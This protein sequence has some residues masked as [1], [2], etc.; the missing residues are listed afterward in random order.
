[1]TARRISIVDCTHQLH[2]RS[3]G[4]SLQFATTVFKTYLNEQSIDYM[5]ASLKKAGI[6]NKL[7]EFFPP[8]KRDNEYFALYF[9]AEDMKQLV[10]YHNQKQRAA[11]EEEIM[12]HLKEM[13]AAENA[14]SEVISYL[15]Q[16][17]KDGHWQEAEFVRI[18]WEGL[19]AAVEWASRPELIE[20]QAKKHVEVC[21]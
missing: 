15:K 20:S 11:M 16:R 17:M 19:M 6:D 14:P 4:L 10:E 13:V 1:M 9:E 8:N 12:E 5:G 18:A 2:A 21:A 3:A 7:M